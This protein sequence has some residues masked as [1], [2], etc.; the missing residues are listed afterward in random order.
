MNEIDCI[1]KYKDE[2]LTSIKRQ[3]GGVKWVFNESYSIYIHKRDRGHF[4]SKPR[5]DEFLKEKRM[6]ENR[7][8]DK[9][10]F[11]YSHYCL[12]HLLMTNSQSQ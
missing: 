1:L 3:G 8:A 12:Q 7:F 11:R 6:S 9:M 2:S 4:I 5:C 10:T